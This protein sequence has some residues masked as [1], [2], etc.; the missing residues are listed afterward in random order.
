MKTV[1][2]VLIFLIEEQKDVALIGDK[3]EVPENEDLV[4]HKM[5][6]IFMLCGQWLQHSC[7]AHASCTRGHGFN[8]PS[9]AGLFSINDVIEEEILP[10]PIFLFSFIN[11]IC[12]CVR[13]REQV[14]RVAGIG[15]I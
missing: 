3:Y 8:S 1:A 13:K 5:L 12:K 11:I 7:R 9:G 4:T 2:V 14:Q 10:P 15:P 6:P